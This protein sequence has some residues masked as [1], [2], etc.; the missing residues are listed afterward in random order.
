ML[1]IN[2]YIYVIYIYKYIYIY[3]W[4][5]CHAHVFEI[6]EIFTPLCRRPDILSSHDQ[7][8]DQ[9]VTTPPSSAMNSALPSM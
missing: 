4:H 5:W 6:I 1:Y 9:Y 3:V 7:Y 8:H 2:I